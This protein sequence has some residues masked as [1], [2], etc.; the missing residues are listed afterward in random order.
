MKIQGISM[1]PGLEPVQLDLEKLF[2]LS[3]SMENQYF[4][5]KI[6]KNKIQQFEKKKHL[7]FSI[8]SY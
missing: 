1:N 8:I 2:L 6:W 5:M 3:D 7:L 4:L